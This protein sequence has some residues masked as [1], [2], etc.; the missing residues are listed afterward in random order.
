MAA[1]GRSYD[2]QSDLV[3][4]FNSKTNKEAEATQA[5]LDEMFRAATKTYNQ[6]QFERQK[7]LADEEG[8]LKKK[9][10]AIADYT[11][12]LNNKLGTAAN[13]R[14][15]A[16]ASV[17]TGDL[18]TQQAAKLNALRREYDA[19]YASLVK[20]QTEHPK[21]ADEYGSKIVE[22]K[23]YY[24]ARVALELD[25]NQRL[26]AARGNW[27]N[28]ATKA[29]QNYLTSA[30]DVA[31]Q[32]E[33]LFT[34]AFQS[35]EDAIVQFS[36]T[37][38]LSFSTMAQSIIA[39]ILR[40]QARQQVAKI[41]SFAMEAIGNL[42]AP[43][44]TD[45]GVSGDSI[46]LAG[47]RA[48]GGPVSAGSSYLVGERGPEIFTPPG[49]GT[50]VPNNALGG[51]GFKVIINNNSNAQVEA[52]PAMDGS[53]IEVFINAIKNSIGEDIAYGT[54]PVN[55]ALQSRYGLRPAV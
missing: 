49:S 41:G 54:G 48:D 4:N 51:G 47:K 32:T 31:G 40:I 10:Q 25:S 9:A 11:S 39:D 16:V 45:T 52:R 34:N 36:M 42:F 27:L 29:T 55:G 53:G 50:I 37:G 26:A 1:E 21:D 43:T 20:S 7:D 13:D 38:K 14:D 3:A 44:V 35:M 6:L 5:R 23:K 28:G 2:R 18:Q 33:G 46:R 19:E 15:I 17:G 8:V 12:A 24:D 30:A 22:L